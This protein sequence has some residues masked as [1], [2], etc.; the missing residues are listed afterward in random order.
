V[1][2]LALQLATSLT[3]WS[4]SAPP[5]SRGRRARRAGTWPPEGGVPPDRGGL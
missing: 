1:Q 3:S 5:P 4:S 2:H